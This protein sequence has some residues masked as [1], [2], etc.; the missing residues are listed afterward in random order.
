[1][2]VNQS[3]LKKTPILTICP[4][5][6]R[7]LKCSDMWKSFEDN[8][9]GIIDLLFCIDEN[10][11]YLKGY[12]QLFSN[13]VAY[14]IQ[15][16]I[17]ITQIYNRVAFKLLPNYQIYHQANDDFR[18]RTKNFDKI[19]MKEFDKQGQ[20]IYYGDDGF[21]KNEMCVAPFITSE[22]IKATGWLQM[23]GLKHLCS[24][25]VW[26]EIGEKLG[27][28]Y[29]IPRIYIMHDHPETTGIPK[30][31][32]TLRVNSPQMYRHD[33]I[34]FSRWFR[35][36]SQKDIALIRAALGKNSR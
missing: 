18:Y 12:Q 2:I 13:D 24:D 6:E 34:E 21:W 14:I 3:C 17:P 11:P 29:Y 22:L 30:D 28:I 25:L 9:S 5:R 27:I 1:M 19:I 10:D 20:G 31:A 32:T 23:T 4:T 26:Q 15:P 16:Q 7:V 36:D 35:Q 33:K 8:E